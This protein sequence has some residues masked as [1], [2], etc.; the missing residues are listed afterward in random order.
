MKQIGMLVA[1]EL[2]SVLRRY[3]TPARFGRIW[4]ATAHRRSRK[5][6]TD[7]VF[8]VIGWTAMN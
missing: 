1:V 8:S 6:G 4:R 5:R 3:G 7:S 2:D